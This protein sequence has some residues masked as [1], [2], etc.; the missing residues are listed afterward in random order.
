MTACTALRLATFAL[1]FAAL[2]ATADVIS[3]APRDTAGLIAAIEYANSS[4][5]E[6]IIELAAGSLYAIDR[7]INDEQSQGLPTIRSRIRILGNGA[8]IRAYTREPLLLVNIANSGTLR[9]EHLTLAEG[10]AGAV[11]NRGDLEVWRVAIVDN[12]ATGS[13]AI[14]TNYGTLFGRHSEIA[15]NELIG[16][17]RDAGI[18][19]NYGKLDLA[20][21]SLQGNRVLRRYAS[22]VSASAILNLGVASLREVS[23]T[24][25]AAGSD[26]DADARSAAL[27]ALGNGR[28]EQVGTRIERNAP[29][30]SA[31]L[32]IPN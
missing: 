1:A 25:N 27:V 11:V 17:Q 23:V 3:V 30:A 21:S 18:V 4:P 13:N 19:L 5:G 8:E 10:T 2:P 20:F 12:S 29:E 15:Y 7:A 24:D 6:D 31:S 16:T 9:L 28:F 14:V 26:A 32:Y 22:L